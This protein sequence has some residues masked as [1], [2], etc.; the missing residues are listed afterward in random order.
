MATETKIIVGKEVYTKTE[1]FNYL[2]TN[3]LNIESDYID[4]TGTISNGNKFGTYYGDFV[5]GVSGIVKEFNGRT[6]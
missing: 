1:F 5:I 2:K 3:K 4:I 6:K